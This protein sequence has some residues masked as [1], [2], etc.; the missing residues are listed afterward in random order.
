MYC[1]ADKII[2]FL[3]VFLKIL[4][5]AVPFKAFT[6]QAQ[7]R[8]PSLCIGVGPVP[9]L[10]REGELAFQQEASVRSG[11]VI[12]RGGSGGAHQQRINRC[13]QGH[14]GGTVCG[15]PCAQGTF[16]GSLSLCLQNKRGAWNQQKQLSN[17]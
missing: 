10:Q 11:D 17:C 1:S 12:L 9:V 8:L 3:T 15:G 5:R 7:L 13:G 4:E 6:S 2:Q 16:A 14:C